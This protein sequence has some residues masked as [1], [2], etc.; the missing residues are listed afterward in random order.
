MDIY[1]TI[2]S[3]V[4]KH[5]LIKPDQT[6]I[7]G[8]SGG[9]DSVFLLHYLA[10]RQKAFNLK[11]IAA[12]LDHEWRAE[13]AQEALFCQNVAEGLGGPYISKKLSELASQLGSPV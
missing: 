3:F 4:T 10:S 12:H 2:D 11:L 1:K 5:D 7:V 13:S 9:P 8:L 6:I